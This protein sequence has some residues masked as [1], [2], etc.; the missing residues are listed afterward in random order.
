MD[1]EDDDEL[2][3]DTLIAKLQVLRGAEGNLKVFYA[4]SYDWVLP[5]NAVSVEQDTNWDNAPEGRAVYLS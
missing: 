5:I 4:S 2:D 3:I 1:N